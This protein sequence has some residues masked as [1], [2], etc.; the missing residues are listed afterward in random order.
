MNI[1]IIIYKLPGLKFPGGHDGHGRRCPSNWP[2]CPEKIGRFRGQKGRALFLRWPPCPFWDQNLRFDTVRLCAHKIK[3]LHVHP[4]LIHA[5]RARSVVKSIETDGSMQCMCVHD[6]E[7]TTDVHPY[8]LCTRS[9]YTGR[10][11]LQRPFENNRTGTH[12]ATRVPTHGCPWWVPANHNF[13]SI[14][15]W[16]S[17]YSTGIVLVHWYSYMF[18]HVGHVT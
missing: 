13:G 8:T 16:A 10:M 14:R 1:S 18:V 11:Y 4:I 3:H 17:A 15:G 2:W 12:L 6:A 7:R 5:H 9:L